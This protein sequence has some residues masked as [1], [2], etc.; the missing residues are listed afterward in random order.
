MT[1]AVGLTAVVVAVTDE[2][3]RI[4]SVRPAGSDSADAGWHR[5]AAVGS[6]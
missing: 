6:V 1:A 3:P 2:V 4:L 5:R